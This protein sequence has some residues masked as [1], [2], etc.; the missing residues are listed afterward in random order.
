[1][2]GHKF[3]WLAALL[4]AAP[5]FSQPRPGEFKPSWKKGPAWLRDVVIYQVY[6]SSYKD[7]DGISPA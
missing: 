1:M 4:V 2:K 7:S 5:L 3:L 6:P